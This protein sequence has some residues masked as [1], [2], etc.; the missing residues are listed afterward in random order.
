MGELEELRRENREL[1]DE[2]SRLK[3]LNE[4]RKKGM[5]KKASHGKVMARPAFG[6]NIVSGKLVP[7]ENFRE[8]EEIFDEFLHS[9]LSLRQISSKH[10]F[11]V[12]GLKKI[13]KNFT[14]IGKI[15]FNNEVFQGSHE[16]IISTTLFNRV[17]DKL[18]KMGVK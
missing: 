18:E 11:S 15:K 8:V 3:A 4:N 10:K 1:K 14:Y 12:N 5:A 17:Q 16:P 7:A 6:Y 9:G 13:L 2:I